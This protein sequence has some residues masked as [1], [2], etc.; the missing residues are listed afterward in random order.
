MVAQAVHE[1]EG[2][3]PTTPALVQF[4]ARAGLITPDHSWA[5]DTLEK[6][7]RIMKRDDIENE[8]IRYKGTS[9]YCPFNN[10]KSTQ[11]S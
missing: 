3:P 1:P 2:M 6:H 10:K 11:C 7:S 4:V 5:A 9:R 8:W